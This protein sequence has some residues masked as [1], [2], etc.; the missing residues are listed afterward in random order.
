MVTDLALYMLGE[1][2]N[3]FH[4]SHELQVC[5]RIVGSSGIRIIRIDVWDAFL[6]FRPT[7]NFFLSFPQKFVLALKSR[8]SSNNL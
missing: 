2:I 8:L 6:F 5:P 1:A 4:N 3:G 7:L